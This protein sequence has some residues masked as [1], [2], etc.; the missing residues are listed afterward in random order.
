MNPNGTQNNI[1][2]SQ[3]K[4]TNSYIN[5]ET[6]KHPMI[7]MI[8]SYADNQ[9]CKIL[10]S[11]KYSLFK[12]DM[13]KNQT[14]Q[15]PSKFGDFSIKAKEFLEKSNQTVRLFLSKTKSTIIDK[16]NSMDEQYLS[17]IKNYIDRNYSD[18]LYALENKSIL[19][20]KN[21]QLIQL[22]KKEAF[23]KRKQELLDK[24][25]LKVIKLPKN[26]GK[27]PEEIRKLYI[28]NEKQNE[29][30][31]QKN[32]TKK[33]YI[34]KVY[35]DFMVYLK[36]NFQIFQQQ[37]T[38]LLSIYQKNIENYKKINEKNKNNTIF[39]SCNSSCSTLL[40][41]PAISSEELLAAIIKEKKDYNKSA[42]QLQIRRIYNFFRL[43]AQIKPDWKLENKN[44]IKKKLSNEK[45]IESIF[46]KVYTITKSKTTIPIKIL[47]LYCLVYYAA[48]HTF[49]TEQ[50]DYPF[51]NE[52]SE[53]YFSDIFRNLSN[54]NNTINNNANTSIDTDK[55][56][57]KMFL[58]SFFNEISA[59][60]NKSYL[61]NKLQRLKN[62]YYV[63]NVYYGNI[64][65]NDR[66][67]ED[68]MYV[69]SDL[70]NIILFN[71]I[72]IFENLIKKGS[73]PDFD[74]IK[75]AN[76]YQGYPMNL[77]IQHGLP[78]I[79]SKFKVMI[80]SF[81]FSYYSSWI[82]TPIIFAFIYK[83]KFR[84]LNSSLAKRNFVLN[85]FILISLFYY[86]NYNFNSLL[87]EINYS[88]VG[89]KLAVYY[90]GQ[91]TLNKTIYVTKCKNYHL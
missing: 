20:L 90:T 87:R 44:K 86:Y 58:L 45:Y 91:E 23:E 81:T 22:K 43:C 89:D 76:Q 67:R 14:P 12:D 5:K 79:H 73:I 78:E 2:L 46:Y 61:N 68:Y 71:E 49:K 56:D 63:N 3:T 31:K 66:N 30:L 64:N 83:N 32:K 8:R 54:K 26:K 1:L 80:N 15:H 17:I 48:Q 42:Y 34:V 41:N 88:L 55:L 37:E 57:K 72:I 13:G 25:I 7:S 82:L 53:K 74:L 28:E 38:N 60:L 24:E 52:E 16:Y 59:S 69:Y 11:N 50:Y 6:E 65:N 29:I 21:K 9:V 18:A 19:S 40:Y 77:S 70:L 84:T 47:V 51:S 10:N 62:I 35:S 36:E 4:T 85:K 39:Y 33:S 75:Q 27:D